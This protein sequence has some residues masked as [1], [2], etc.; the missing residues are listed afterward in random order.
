[1]ASRKVNDFCDISIYDAI[2]V[3]DEFSRAALFQAG[4]AATVVPD[5]TLTWDPIVPRGKRRTIVVTASNIRGSW[6]TNAGYR[7]EYLESRGCLE[8]SRA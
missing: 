8:E 7:I 2:F 6:N 4:I 3:R 1:M 5:L